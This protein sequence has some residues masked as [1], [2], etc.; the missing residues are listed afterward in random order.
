MLARMYWFAL[1]LISIYLI[2]N[3]QAPSAST[4]ARVD[5][6]GKR[7]SVHADG[8]ALG[9]L[10]SMVEKQTG[11][12][13][14]Y[15]DSLAETIVYANF[16]NN[17]LADGIKRILSQLNHA[18]VYDGSGDIRT[19]LIVGCQMASLESQ[20]NQEELYASQPENDISVTLSEQEEA[21]PFSVQG[22]GQEPDVHLLPPGA[23]TPI[24]LQIPPGAE[25]PIPAQLPP[26]AGTTLPL[27]GQPSESSTVSLQGPPGAELRLP[28]PGAENQMLPPPMNQSDDS[29]APSNTDEQAPPQAD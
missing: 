7:L 6:D 21:M 23:E 11:V 1:V 26:G 13:F 24:P 14:S 9:E 15:D 27:Q 5:Y 8:V 4:T 18:I 22:P 19:V 17:V 20:G 28:P 16:E 3:V 12:R 25:V 29:S 10:L 2:I